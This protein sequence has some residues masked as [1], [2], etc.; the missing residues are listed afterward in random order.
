MP[1]G[2]SPSKLPGVTTRTV[3]IELELQVDGDDVQGR[4]IDGV[5]T[6]RDFTGW[7]G[8]IAALDALLGDAAPEIRPPT[9]L[10]E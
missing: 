9:S 3:T 7:L 10:G 4:A 6:R 8:L 5:G 1:G 2:C